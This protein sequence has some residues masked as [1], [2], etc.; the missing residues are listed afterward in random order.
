[1]W[2]R[3]TATEF[4]RNFADLINRVSYRG[5]RLVVT[6]GG[7]DL[8]EI[9]PVVRGGRLGE[10]PG[11][12]ASLPRLDPEEAAAFATDVEAFMGE[13]GGPGEPWEF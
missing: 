3:V 6:R 12:L 4:V 9:R 10:L 13:V 8:A 5:E 1:M 2:R 11:L 7:K